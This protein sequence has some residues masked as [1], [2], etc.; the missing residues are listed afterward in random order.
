[1]KKKLIYIIFF[2]FSFYI[3]AGELSI[4]PALIFPST[5]DF[6]YNGSNKVD[7]E[8]MLGVSID[9]LFPL[10]SD[11]LLGIGG[12]FLLPAKSNQTKSVGNSLFSMATPYVDMCYIVFQ[13][14]KL[15]QEQQNIKQTFLEFQAGYPILYGI[16]Q[17]SFTQ[18]SGLENTRAKSN[19]Y[20]AVGLGT[21]QNHIFANVLYTIQLFQLSGQNS[22]N[23]CVHGNLWFPATQLN[24]GY[25]L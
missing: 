4:S 13:N 25:T 3:F 19:Y 22:S 20:F 12:K 5:L 23:E 16:N 14:D 17:T 7:S 10:T 2:I 18:I 6:N 11:L 8:A 15:E 9:Y 1:M 21:I 24:I